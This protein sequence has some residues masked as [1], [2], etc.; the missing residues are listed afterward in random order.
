MVAPVIPGLNDHE[1]PAILKAASEHGA[2][3]AG[4]IMLRLPW[5]IKA[6]FLEWLSRWFPAR[7]GKVEGLVR[8]V[9]GGA[10][11]KADFGTRQR[12]EGERAGQIGAAFEV[13]ARRCGLEGVGG[14][15]SSAAFRKRRAGRGQLGLFQ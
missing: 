14:G 5:Q 15:L 11:Y 6:L 2:T 12:G 10:L 8:E 4:W 9:R 1:I 3:S 13:F 7:A